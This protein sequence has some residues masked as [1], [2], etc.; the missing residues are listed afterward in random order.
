MNLL[1]IAM[2][3]SALA[4]FVADRLAALRLRVAPRRIRRK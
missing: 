2:F 4:P 3:A 1:D